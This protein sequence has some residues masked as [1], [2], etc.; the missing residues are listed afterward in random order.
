MAVGR[1]STGVRGAREVGGHSGLSVCGGKALG[2]YFPKVSRCSGRV[3][4]PVLDVNE[5]VLLGE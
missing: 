5:C 4:D 3:P 1:G 2:K